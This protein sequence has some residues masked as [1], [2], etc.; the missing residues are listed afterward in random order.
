MTDLDS[1]LRAADPYRPADLDGADAVL[2]EEIVAQSP[3]DP[4]VRLR[5]RRIR[6]GRVTLKSRLAISV[7]TAAAV[8]AAI[9]VPVVIAG[10]DA[11]AP[12][13]AGGPQVSASPQVVTPVRYAA[14]A[15][16]VAE[17]NP[18]VLVTGSDWKVRSMEGFSA[19]AGQ[20]SFQRGPDQYRQEP[21][22]GTRMSPEKRRAFER[23][24]ANGEDALSEAGEGPEEIVGY[25]RSNDAP[26]L[27]VAWY[28]AAQHAD[29]I[30]S[31]SG[32]GDPSRWV[33]LWG[34]KALLVSYS[35]GD[36]AVVL[37]VQGKVFLEL[38]GHS[39]GDEAAFLAFLTDSVEQVDVPTWLAAM[40]PEV[41]T[42]GGVQKALERVLADIP[43]PPGFDRN[44]FGRAQALD[45]Y[46]FGAAVTG[47]VACGWIDEWKQA[48]AAGDDAAAKHAADQLAT[49]HDW[50]VLQEMDADG[51]FPEVVWEYADRMAA[52]QAPAGA[53][54]GLGC[55]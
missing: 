41:V 1:R 40:P 5:A 52:G 47:A 50:K 39:L 2:M 42:V 3:V 36:H 54:G 38:R 11:V 6:R 21:V 26:S 17:A 16:K 37:P 10:Q 15:V 29:W 48:R 27:K 43:V 53:H 28:P 25:S 44:V 4:A 49:S 46:Q 9:A 51:D 55:R 19:A 35:A 33:E 8:T 22:Y 12:P 7:A 23:A 24:L 30:V 18:R 32:K 34:R 31:R 20:M 14:A 45:S 13:R